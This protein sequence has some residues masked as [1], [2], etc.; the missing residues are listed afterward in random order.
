MDHVLLAV[1]LLN[2]FIL[3]TR[4]LVT[5]NVYEKLLLINSF[6]THVIILISIF[7]LNSD[8]MAMIDIA[9]V[10]SFIGLVSTMVFSYYFQRGLC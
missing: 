1:L 5:H 9:L 10:Y 8:N 3:L 7:A 6:S 2:S 4:L